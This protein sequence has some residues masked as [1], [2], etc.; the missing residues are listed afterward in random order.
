MSQIFSNFDLENFWEQSDYALEEYVE[1]PPSNETIARVERQLGYK[2]PSSYIELMR[3]Q[4]GGMPRRTMHR[5]SETH[6]YIAITGIF[7]IGFE[8]PYSLCGSFGSQFWEKEWEYPPIGVYFADCPS[9]GHEMICM[10]Y[11]ICGPKGEPQIVYI[12]QEGGHEIVFLAKTFEE[13]IRGL[14]GKSAF[15]NQ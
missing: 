13:F 9:A 7:S 8:K 3:T 5:K 11:Q 4:N 10:D 2:L 14:K 1:L 15:N 12:D 6:D